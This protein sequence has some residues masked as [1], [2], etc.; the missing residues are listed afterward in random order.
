MSVEHMKS[1]LSGFGSSVKHHADSA[2][3]TT[4][5]TLKHTGSTLKSGGTSVKKGLEQRIHK[6]DEDLIEHYRQDI[7]RTSKALKY[8]RKQSEQVAKHHWPRVFKANITITSQFLEVIGEDSLQFEGIEEYYHEFDLLQTETEIPIVHPKERQVTISSV[9]HELTNYLQSLK[10]LEMKIL[11]EATWHAKSIGLR[12]EQMNKHLR[13]MLKLIKKR[14]E[15]KS[16][17]DK[18]HKRINKLMKK[19]SPLDEKEQKE[20]SNLDSE[21][22]VA[23]KEFTTLD[24]KLKSILPHAFSFLEEFI[25]NL[26]QMIVLKQ[27]DIF[28]EID[29]TLRYFSIFHGFTNL[30]YQDHKDDLILTYDAIVNQWETVMTPT[31]LQLESFITI[32]NNKN[33]DLIDEEI[34]DEKK[35]LASEKFLSKMNSKWNDRS[36]KLKPKDEANGVFADYLTADP[37]DSFLKYENPNYNRSETYHPTR[38]LLIDEVVVPAPISPKAPPLPPR[39]NTADTAKALPAIP[40]KQAND[41]LPPL[42]PRKLGSSLPPTPK[43][44]LS[45]KDSSDSFE[46]IRSDDLDS[47]ILS[48]DSSNPSTLNSTVLLENSSPDLVNKSIVKVYNSAKNDIKEAPITSTNPVYDHITP[49]HSDL[50]EKTSS[51]TYRLNHVNSFFDKLITISNSASVQREVLEAKYDFKGDEP[52][53]MSFKKGEKIEILFDFQLVD[54]L[55]SRDNKNWMI[56][57]IPSKESPRVGFVPNNYF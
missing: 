41:P 17:Y 37:L 11:N 1:N 54:T 24:D 28:K 36:H 40:G 25:E 26:T 42:P 4:G 8:L 38:V 47:S 27:L 16:H 43:L 46:S 44:S 2:L 49:N 15:K 34:N 20:M 32:V 10:F 7:K 23:S 55:Y 6:N 57:Y 19:S 31:K 3:K 14:N 51:I 50:F 52:G 56:G 33:P 5:S 29:S 9:H 39:S 30:K 48:D 21:L 53:D 45:R 22:K 12:I 35:T 13:D 18:I